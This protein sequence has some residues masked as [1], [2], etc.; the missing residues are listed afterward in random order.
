MVGTN[1]TK[2]THTDGLTARVIMHD[3]FQQLPFD[4]EVHFQFFDRAVDIPV[5]LQ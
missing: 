2:W 1:H 4:R 3:K 5:V